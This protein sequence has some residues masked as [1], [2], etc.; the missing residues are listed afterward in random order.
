VRT[1]WAA[2]ATPLA[3][4]QLAVYNDRV[5]IGRRGGGRDGA[6]GGDRHQ[7]PRRSV[8]LS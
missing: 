1:S 7:R 5:A 4:V 6:D 3:S 8:G 2:V